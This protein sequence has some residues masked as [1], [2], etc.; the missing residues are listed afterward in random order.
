MNRR[1]GG[2][3]WIGSLTDLALQ[4]PDFYRIANAVGQLRRRRRAERLA[5]GVGLLGAGALVGA[6]VAALLTPKTGPEI[7][8][9]ISDQ[10]GRVRDYVAGP[11]LDGADE[12]ARR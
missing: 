7:R 5:R 3:D 6:G 10:A 4:A 9:R 11:I 12:D 1:D 8:R 2:R